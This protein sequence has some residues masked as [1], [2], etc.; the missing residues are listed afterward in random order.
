[1]K[2]GS[3]DG[4][5]VKVSVRQPLRLIQG[6]RD[7]GIERYHVSSQAS[8]RAGGKGCKTPMLTF[9]NQPQTSN[10]QKHEQ[11]TNVH[12]ESSIRLVHAPENERNRSS[13]CGY[14]QCTILT[15]TQF[16]A[17]LRLCVNRTV[18]NSK[19]CLRCL[20]ACALSWKKKHGQFE[21]CG[22]ANHGVM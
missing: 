15:P 9:S 13:G 7:K 2:T 22:A 3:H 5:D 4:C 6:T 1:M 18:I 12:V 11:P 14:H 16:K 20:Y 19:F 21:L 10:T 8:G 17:Q